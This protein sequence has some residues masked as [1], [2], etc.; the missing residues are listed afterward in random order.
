MQQQLIV[1]GVIL[2]S[3]FLFVNGSIRY[4]FVALIALLILALTGIVPAGNAFLGFGHP[5]V[6]TVAAILVVSSALLKTGAL[7]QL[8]RFL[9][10]GGRSVSVKIAAL[11]IMTAVLSSFMN[12]VGALALIMP[13]AIKV[14][15]HHKIS[16][17]YL[18]MPVA[19]ASLLGGLVTEIGTP[20]NLIISTYRGNAGLESFSFF[21]FAPVGIG[22]TGVGII[23]ISF[24]GWHLIPK[25]KSDEAQTD[26]FEVDDYMSEVYIPE[27]NKNISKSIR[28]LLFQLNL[29]INI[30]SII[31]G[32]KTIIAPNASDRIEE[33]DLLVIR[34]DHVELSKL[35]E[36]SGFILKGSKVIYDESGKM[37]SDE[38]HA[39]VEIVLRDDS[40]AIGRNIVELDLR[41]IYSANLVAVSRKG[42]SSYYRLKSHRFRPGDILLIQCSKATLQ[43]TVSKLRGL[44]LAERGVDLSSS[45][46][47]LKRNLT[48]GLFL[49]SIIATTAGLVSVQISFVSCAI[50]MVLINV[51]TPR[52]FYEAI[53]WPIV[54]MLGALLPVGEALQTTGGADTIAGLMISAMHLLS[55]SLMVVLLM[56]ITML[57]T[58]LI[59]N[60]AAAVLMAPIAISLSVRMGVSV[61]PLLMAVAVSASSAFMTP[62]G[63]QSCTL[64]MGPGGYRFGDYWRMGLPVSILVLITGTPLLLFFWPL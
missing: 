48:I 2:G 31:R 60:A 22:V 53:E 47:A 30:V 14:G 23:F 10:K 20:P 27:G 55:P 13:I 25:R 28:E 45:N 33:C 18:L 29:D 11:M 16:A 17:S 1:F 38:E 44:P 21:D 24:I 57:L 39:I 8:V 36:K 62:I 35:I 5:A 64:V 34:A 32:K 50:L 3:L 37:L 7:D 9:N 19:F 12:N 40:P 41:R 59:N 6:I 63:H 51:I 52:E 56:V 42:I 46:L 61:D 26:F 4:D 58:N 54:I 15:K 43:D 49:L